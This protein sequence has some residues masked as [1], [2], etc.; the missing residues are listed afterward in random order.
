MVLWEVSTDDGFASSL[1]DYPSV[2]FHTKCYLSVIH[3]TVPV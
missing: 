3:V 1:M 2:R